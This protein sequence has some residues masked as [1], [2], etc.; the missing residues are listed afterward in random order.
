MSE[1]PTEIAKVA[2]LIVGY[3]NADDI[4]CCLSALSQM[5][6]QPDFE[7]FVCE[8]GGRDAY[9]LLLRRLVDEAT[10][11]LC[12]D[13]DPNA[14]AAGAPFLNVR[15]LRL[16]GR[17]AKVTI[18]CADANLGYGGGVNAWLRRLMTQPGWNGVWILN[19]DAEPAPDALAA[20]VARAEAGAKGM[21]GS[22]IL[23]SGSQEVIRFRGGIQWR[24]FTARCAAIGLGERLD[25]RVDLAAIERAMESPSGASMYVTRA[26]IDAIGL[27]DESYFLFFEDLDWGARAKKLGLGYASA[28]VVAHQRGT[29]TGSFGHGKSLSRLAVYLE[30]RNAIHFVRRHHPWALPTRIVISA[31]EAMRFLIRRAPGSCMA[32]LAGLSAGVQGERGL[33]SWHR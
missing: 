15:R 14:D 6:P 17:G 1:P 31:A 26:C 20:L 18:G 32:A 11:R 10:C 27:M 33:P 25:A 8:N 9:E 2:V 16:V 3:K 23:E 12:E 29:T 21:V 24:K 30:H 13:D 19:P 5:T 4:V 22:T 28:S 7:V